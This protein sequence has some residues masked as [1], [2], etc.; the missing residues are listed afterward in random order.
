M[1]NNYVNLLMTPKV[2][3]EYGWVA[4]TQVSSASTMLEVIPGLQWMTA[5]GSINIQTAGLLRTAFGRQEM[6][7]QHTRFD[8][9]H[10]IDC[11]LC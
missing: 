7:I 2:W 6:V 10:S 3:C 5:F 11:N 1:I 8:E 4:S 9:E